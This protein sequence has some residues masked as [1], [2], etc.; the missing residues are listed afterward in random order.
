MSTCKYHELLGAYYD[1]ELDAKT[2]VALEDHLDDCPSCMAELN[3]I[4]RL[5]QLLRDLPRP[6]ASAEAVARFHTVVDRAPS[7]VLQHM[8][9]ALTAAAAAILLLCGVWLWKLPATGGPGCAA[10]VSAARD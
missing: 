4:R 2:H 1:G 10:G 6:Q 9:E 7:T 3:R 8:A 5:S